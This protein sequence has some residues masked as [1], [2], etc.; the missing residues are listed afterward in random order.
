MSKASEFILNFDKEYKLGDES[1]DE[2]HREFLALVEQASSANST[3][4]VDTM[5]ALFEHT[6]SHF[7]QEEATMADIGHSLLAEHK[8]DHQRILGDMDRLYQ[9]A[10]AGRTAMARAWVSDS[11]LAWFSTHAKTMDSALAAQLLSE[12]ACA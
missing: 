8:A 7:A 12:A 11:L 3:Q 4:F 1:M 9:R 2:T 5:K 10:I 6:Q